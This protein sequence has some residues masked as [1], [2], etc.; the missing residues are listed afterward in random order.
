M[1]DITRIHHVAILTEN[2]LYAASKR[3]YTDIMGFKVLSEVY[4]KQRDSYKLDLAIGELYQIELFSFPDFKERA[5]YPEAKG[6]RHLAFAVR[7]LEK[8][9]NFLLSM[10]VEAEPIRTD[11]YTGKK[12]CFFHDPN[13]QPLELYAL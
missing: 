1:L 9:R 11:C 2:S 13:G 3:F 6:L 10:A 12:Y 4:R 7:D 5:S 8:S